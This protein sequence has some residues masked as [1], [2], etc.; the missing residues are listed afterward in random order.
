MK[1]VKPPKKPLIFYYLIVLAIL[2]ALNLFLMPTLMNRS[3]E[4][5]GY[6][7]FLSKLSNGE[8]V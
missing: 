6:S 7:E 4:E 8:V 2:L 3:I 1:E 5:V